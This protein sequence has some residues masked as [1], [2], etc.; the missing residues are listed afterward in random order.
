MFKIP[1]VQKRRQILHIDADAFFASVEQI[2]NPKLKGKPVLVGGPSEKKGI[3]SAASYEARKFGVKSGMPMYLAKRK[4][5]KAIVVSGHFDIY[6][7]FSRRMYQILIKHSPYTEMASIDEAY[8]DI[9]GFSEAFG[10]TKENFVKAMLMEIYSKLGLSVSCGLASSK[11]V[12]KVA[13]SINKPHKFT[14]IPYGKERAFLKDLELRKMPG[15]GPST[16]TMLQRFGYTKIGDIA[17][18]SLNEVLEKFGMRGIYIWK[19]CLGIDNTPVISVSSLPKSISKEHTFYSPIS[20]EK[21]LLS[22]LKGL[23]EKVFMKL[24][25]YEMKAKSINIKIRYKNYE[26]GKFEDFS[27]QTNLD[28]ARSS[29]FSLFPKAKELFLKNWDRGREVRLIGIGVSKLLRNYN[30][31]LFERDDE[32]EELFMRI[33]SLKQV[34]GKDILKVGS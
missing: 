13:S 32:K 26:D 22:E 7:D 27:F 34:Y 8:L 28:L 20:S 29:D 9:T 18:L 14:V 12:A 21:V 19:K 31:A 25:L 24:R 16:S 17:N 1:L 15:I 2:V 6:R 10:D 5:P 33:D 11:T 4:C 3:V 30:L 23:S